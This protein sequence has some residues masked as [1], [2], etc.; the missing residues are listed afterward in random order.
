M[1][2]G[3]AGARGGVLVVDKSIMA[4]ASILRV[5]LDFEFL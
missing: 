5:G 3:A 4:W 2:V 1:S